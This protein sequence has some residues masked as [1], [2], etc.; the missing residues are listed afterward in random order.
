MSVPG[1]QSDLPVL[2]SESEESDA[3]EESNREQQDQMKEVLSFANDKKKRAAPIPRKYLKVS[4]WSLNDLLDELVL[5]YFDGLE[6]I[7]LLLGKG[8]YLQC[9]TVSNQAHRQYPDERVWL[10]I[11]QQRCKVNKVSL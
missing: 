7:C 6:L 10:E 11:H 9:T 3:S 1:R 2:R 4:T 8:S 5:Q